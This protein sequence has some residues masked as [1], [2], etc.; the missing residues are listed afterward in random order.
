MQKSVKKYLSKIGTKGG[1]KTS[2]KKKK[3]S[4]GNLAAWRAKK[5]KE[6]INLDTKLISE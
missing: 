1:S 2:D 5:K 6:K 4:S 3:S